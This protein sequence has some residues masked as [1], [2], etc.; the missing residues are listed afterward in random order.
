MSERRAQSVVL[1]S[2]D[3]LRYDCV[4]ACPHKLHLAA[5]G[6]ESELHTPNLDAFFDEAVYF[7][8]CLTSAPNTTTAHASLMTGLYPAHHGARAQFKWGLAEGVTTLAQVLK[9]R[10]YTTV[11]VQEEGEVTVLRTG[12]GVLDGFDHFFDDEAEACRYCRDIPGPVL[13][14]L[15]T[16]DV[17]AP[18]CWSYLDRVC[19]QSAARQAAEAQVAEQL[20]VS[21]PAGD[22]MGEQMA[23]RRRASRSARRLLDGRAAARL[24][25][26]WY[27]RG[28]N[29][30]DAVRWP[31]IVGA[32]RDAGLYDDALVAVFADHGE[33]L[34]PDFRGAPLDH[35]PSLLEDVLRIPLAVRAPDLKAARTDRQVSIVD[36]APTALDYL[37]L[38][39]TRIGRDGRTDG[40][41]LLEAQV[42]SDQAVHFAEV[43]SRAADRRRG[44][45]EDHHFLGDESLPWRPYQVCARAGAH[46]VFWHPGPPRLERFTPAARLAM[47]RVKRWLRQV[48]PGRALRLLA[49]LQGT[50]PTGRAGTRD[51]GSTTADVN[52]RDAPSFGVDLLEDPFE[53][54]P[55]LLAKG[56]KEG[57]Y[58]P[59]LDRIRAYWEGGVI[60][61]QIDLQRGDLDTV[62]RRLRHLGYLE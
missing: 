4:G 51:A 25:L 29:W 19:R 21:P 2:I 27:V 46:K 9:A 42:P 39:D 54:K 1:I 5:C 30:F 35:V 18:Y 38:E 36:L 33:A 55:V 12:S 15:H 10:G 41:S 43:W 52:W 47:L 3:T 17:H 22:S 59:L 44:S 23:F 40:R 49:K 56:G 60:G 6:L 14:F 20:H 58:G 57:T 7:T 11:A 26:H 50:A 62:A 53:Q 24:F 16:F 28:V 37:G 34:L 45:P 32:L 13:L 48:L 8:G 31:G 61:P